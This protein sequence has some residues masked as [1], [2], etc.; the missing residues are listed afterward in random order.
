MHSALGLRPSG[1]Y[2]MYF[3]G[4]GDWLFQIEICEYFSELVKVYFVVDASCDFHKFLAEGGLF[5]Y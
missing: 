3:F 1:W 4:G 5:D 2:E